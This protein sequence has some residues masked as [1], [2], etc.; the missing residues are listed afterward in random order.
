MSRKKRSITSECVCVARSKC[1][2]LCERRR[3]WDGGETMGKKRAST[4]VSVLCYLSPTRRGGT[5]C[6]TG[7]GRATHTSR[8][9]RGHE[10]SH[11]GARRF[12]RRP[13][14]RSRPSLLRL[15][16]DGNR[17]RTQYE[18]LMALT[19][20]MM[21]HRGS[22]TLCVTMRAGT[23]K[24]EGRLQASETRG[25]LGTATTGLG[26]PAPTAVQSRRAAG[27]GIRPRRLT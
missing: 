26:V 23:G 15:H 19:K 12:S 18:S 13:S 3:G 20:D 27:W 1:I 14:P 24:P 4:D 16:T 17:H 5:D 6:A 7:G 10:R 25:W 21:R 22:E 8:Q 9:R 2:R 11:P